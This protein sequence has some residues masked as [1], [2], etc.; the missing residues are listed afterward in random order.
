MQQLV[1]ITKLDGHR[2]L[3]QVV[4][5]SGVDELEALK[6][7]HGLYNKGQLKEVNAPRAME[8]KE[9]DNFLGVLRNKLLDL[10]GPAADVTLQKAFE[11]LGIDPNFL[12][13]S[14][15]PDVFESVAEQLDEM[16]SEVFDHWKNG[17]AIELRKAG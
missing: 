8:K 7:I 11:S 17:Y 5:E 2:T 16:E 13:R 9:I 15:I 10:V 3:R 12:S 4:A 6:F 14:Q 1:L